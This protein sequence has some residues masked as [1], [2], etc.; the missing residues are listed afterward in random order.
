MK[1]EDLI[2]DLGRRPPRKFP[3]G[4][5]AELCTAAL[6]SLLTATTLSVLWLK[7]RNDLAISLIV[8]NNVFILKFVFC[9]GVVA[10]ALAILQKLSLP[11][12]AVTSGLIAIPFLTVIALAGHELIERYVTGLSHSADHTWLECLWQIPALALPA[13]VILG[14]VVRRLAPTDLNRTGAYLGL[15]AGGIGA[16]GY[17]FHCHHDS[18]LFVGIAYSLAIIEMALLGALVGPYVL[19][20]K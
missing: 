5:K 19:R 10:A 3:I 9:I 13:L 8:A 17:A 18:V 7:P 14:L 15:L 16:T 11:G 6:F 2:A 20:W 12:R 1:T 4:P